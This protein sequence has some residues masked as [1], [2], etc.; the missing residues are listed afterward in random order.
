MLIIFNC[1]LVNLPHLH[2]VWNVHILL[3][4]PHICNCSGY[5]WLRVYPGVLYIRKYNW[6]FWR[7]F[8]FFS[9]KQNMFVLYIFPIIAFYPRFRYGGTFN[10]PCAMRSPL[11]FYRV[12]NSYDIFLF[13]ATKKSVLMHTR[14]YPQVQNIY[15][16]IQY[17]TALY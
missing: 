11:I 1:W 16:P 15:F 17:K 6:N 2:F 14:T 5:S 10:Y 3:E 13:C 8:S 12:I 7:R 4:T 9:H